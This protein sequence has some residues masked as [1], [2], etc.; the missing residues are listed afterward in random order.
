MAGTQFEDSNTS[1]GVLNLGSQLGSHR[2]QIPAMPSYDE[3][4]S[5]QLDSPSSHMGQ[6]LATRGV[7]LLIRQNDSEF[8]D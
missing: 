4:L 2:P 6:H 3:P 1:G 7:R 8:P 5:V